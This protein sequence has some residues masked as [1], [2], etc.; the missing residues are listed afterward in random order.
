M[1]TNRKRIN[2]EPIRGL[3]DPIRFLL[4]TRNPNYRK[5]RFEGW[6]YNF[7]LASPS[8]RDELEK[9]WFQHRGTILEEWKGRGKRGK[10][11]AEKELGG[12]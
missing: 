12:G 10:P 2:R 11:R 6:A 3:T 1:P 9:I 7:L 8:I 4:E 5:E